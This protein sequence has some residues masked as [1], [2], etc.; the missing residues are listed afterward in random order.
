[1]LKR[2]VV[3]FLILLAI[4]IIFSD[5]IKMPKIVF[6]KAAHHN[7][8]GELPIVEI[9]DDG[10]FYEKDGDEE[11]LRE[12][13]VFLLQEK[14]KTKY[15]RCLSDSKLNCGYDNSCKKRK[16]EKCGKKY[17]AEM[18]KSFKVYYPYTSSLEFYDPDYDNGVFHG[19][20]NN[21]LKGYELK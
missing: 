1:M 2:I 7:T 18:D 21:F 12:K 4:W 17:E 3:V 14:I 5:R 19:Y 6:P 8:I 10:D 11:R 16:Y 20:S 9:M 13:K 15:I